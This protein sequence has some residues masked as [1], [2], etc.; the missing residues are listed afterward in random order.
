MLSHYKRDEGD[1]GLVGTDPTV[2]N[3]WPKGHRHQDYWQAR[4]LL[5]FR[6]CQVGKVG[7]H[8]A[9]GCA[10]FCLTLCVFWKENTAWL[11]AGLAWTQFHTCSGRW[12]SPPA[13]PALAALC[14]GIEVWKPTIPQAQD[15]TLRASRRLQTK[16]HVAPRTKS[17]TQRS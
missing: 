3:G 10:C 8:L 11:V 9:V 12:L 2:T 16:N 17:P 5:I 4:A 14:T 13:I 7:A 1:R 15:K 6:L